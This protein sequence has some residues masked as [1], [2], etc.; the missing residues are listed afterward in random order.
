M[1]PA[2]CAE[3]RGM[4]PRVRKSKVKYTESHKNKRDGGFCL[5]SQSYDGFDKN[6]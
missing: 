4:R 3:R 1:F 6:R 2:S 5:L